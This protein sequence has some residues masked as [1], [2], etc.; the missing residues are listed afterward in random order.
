MMGNGKLMDLRASILLYF[1][2]W[3]YLVKLQP[4]YSIHSRNYI[5]RNT[6]RIAYAKSGKYLV[7]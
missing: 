6:L 7:L 3:Q 1:F 2:G 4:P 5:G